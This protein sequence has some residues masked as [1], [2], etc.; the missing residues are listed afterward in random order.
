MRTSALSRLD[1]R[2][3]A[4]IVERLSQPFSEAV[5]TTALL[6]TPIL[7]L[8]GA[9]GGNLTYPTSDQ[10]IDSAGHFLWVAPSSCHPSPCQISTDSAFSRANS[11]ATNDFPLLPR[12]TPRIHSRQLALFAGKFAQCMSPRITPIYANDSAR[13]AWSTLIRNFADY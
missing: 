4:L 13:S 1:L 5:G 6:S 10:C 2:V 9:L 3:A 11:T 8:D 12:A 7:K